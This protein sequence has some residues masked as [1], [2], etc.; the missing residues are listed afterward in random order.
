[1]TTFW[2]SM[3]FLSSFLKIVVSNTDVMIAYLLSE[4][5][6]TNSNK[7]SHQINSRC[8]CNETC[9]TRVFGGHQG[10]D[11]SSHEVPDANVW[12][13]TCPR[14]PSAPISQSADHLKTHTVLPTCP[15]TYCTSAMYQ[16]M[17]SARIRWIRWIE[18]PRKRR[19]LT[20]SRLGRIFLK[21]HIGVAIIHLRVCPKTLN[22]HWNTKVNSVRK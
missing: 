8:V 4:K 16:L 13:V 1:M 11:I 6:D 18:L 22:V 3:L 12:F 14:H 9:G 19:E 5:I 2:T 7:R 10:V 17:R 20:V 21:I 15:C